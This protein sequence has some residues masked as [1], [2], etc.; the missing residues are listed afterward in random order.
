MCF[1]LTCDWLCNAMS[2]ILWLQLS[3]DDMLLLQELKPPLLRLSMTSWVPEQLRCLIRNIRV[4]IVTHG[5]V[6]LDVNSQIPT[7]E[8]LTSCIDLLD[9]QVD[10][11][12]SDMTSN[13]TFE[14]TRSGSG[15][16]LPSG[17]VTGVEHTALA[18]SVTGTRPKVFGESITGTMPKGSGE[19]DTGSGAK[20]SNTGSRSKVLAEDVMSSRAK[21]SV[22]S[23]TR[24]QPK[25]SAEGAPRTSPK[26]PSKGSYEEALVELTD[27]LIAVKGHALIQLTKLIQRYSHG[28]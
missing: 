16:Q 20:M 17:G 12:N 1:A 15:S 5:L 14:T 9:Q 19:S 6:S 21:A 10:R 18:P 2:Y 23:D 7:D 22:E 8:V 28:L 11:K 27:H 4:Y 26:V 13:D 3:Q 24:A 25:M